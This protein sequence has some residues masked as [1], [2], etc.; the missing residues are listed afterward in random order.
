MGS[1]LNEGP[2]SRLL[3][4]GAVIFVGSLEKRP[5]SAGFVCWVTVYS[6]TVTLKAPCVRT[7]GT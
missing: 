4:N 1:L 3:Y 2:F 7:L 5:K 6:D